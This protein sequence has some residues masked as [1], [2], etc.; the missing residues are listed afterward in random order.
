[1]YKKLSEWG[2]INKATA[3]IKL[4]PRFDSEMA[5]EGLFGMVVKI[6]DDVGDGWHYIETHYKY[7]GYIHEYNIILDDNRAVEWKKTAN[8]II[9]HSIVDVMAASTYKSYIIE[10]L[11]RGSV[12]LVTG[13]EKEGWTEIELPDNR[14]G[15]VRS[16]FLGTLKTTS[17][18][19]DE[20][21]LR[22]NLVNTALSYLGTQ[23]RWGGRSPFGIDCSGLCSISYLLNGIIIYRDAVLKDEYMRNITLEEI[24]PGDLIFF[25]GH[26][27]MYIGDDKF[28]HS[29][30]SI[31]G[32]NIN[33]LNPN[34]SDYR[35]DLAETIT[36]VGTIY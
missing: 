29:S 5:D 31:N 10:V 35:K 14:R 20:D 24:K 34:H 26:V 32:V 12:V 15:W 17:N 7:S 36:G 33:S 21:T 28:V 8:S 11:G 19:D 27:A 16:A 13:R 3:P 6:L 22:K 18:K 25:P 23:Y 2:I 30:S 9:T 1:M 4:H